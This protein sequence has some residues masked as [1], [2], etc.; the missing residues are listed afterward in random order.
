MKVVRVDDKKAKEFL[1]NEFYRYYPGLPDNHIDKI[2]KDKNFRKDVFKKISERGR[3]DRDF[4][5]L[6]MPEIDFGLFLAYGYNTYSIISELNEDEADIV[7]NHIMRCTTKALTPAR[8]VLRVIEMWENVTC[9]WIDDRMDIFNLLQIKDKVLQH[10]LGSKIEGWFL[11][12]YR[13]NYDSTDISILLDECHPAFDNKEFGED[14]K[15]IVIK[16]LNKY[17]EEEY[18]DEEL[19]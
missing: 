15:D 18:Y 3:F 8:M 11:E 7:F 17:Y 6:F 5:F 12:K 9:K 2:M 14:L 4:M 1:R 19:E 10:M 13:D 16:H